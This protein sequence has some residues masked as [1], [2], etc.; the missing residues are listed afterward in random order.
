[1][2]FQDLLTPGEN[3]AGEQRAGKREILVALR[4][5]PV[6]WYVGQ[7]TDGYFNGLFRLPF[8]ANRP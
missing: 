6:E 4:R 3:R 7:T 5:N 2:V 1:L 8:S